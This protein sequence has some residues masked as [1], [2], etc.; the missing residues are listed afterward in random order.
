MF[1]WYLEQPGCFLGITS[2]SGTQILQQN[3]SGPC[4]WGDV[5]CEC[6]W[7]H[8][9]ML[10]LSLWQGQPQSW[11]SLLSV[12]QHRSNRSSSWTNSFVWG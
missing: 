3:F 4:G 12:S 1:S 5:N 7:E 2:C 8:P 9:P 6:F 11:L 10:G